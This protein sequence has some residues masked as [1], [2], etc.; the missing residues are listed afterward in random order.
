MHPAHVSAVALAH[1]AGSGAPAQPAFPAHGA[2]PFSVESAL[3]AYHHAAYLSSR[4]AATAAHYYREFPGLFA[5]PGLLA[6]LQSHVSSVAA[7][8]SLADAP[9]KFVRYEPAL[10]A[11]GV[12]VRVLIGTARN[13]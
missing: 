6:H 13:L 1:A 10:S 7:N 4:R 3:A 11:V 12:R 9:G 5:A 2:A 8:S